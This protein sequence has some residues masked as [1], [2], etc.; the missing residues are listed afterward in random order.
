MVKLKSQKSKLKLL[1][2]ITL[3]IGLGFSVYY[4]VFTRGAW[5]G[6][7][8]FTL[9][10]VKNG[11]QVA[12]FDPQTGDGVKISFPRNWMIDG[13]DGKGEWLAEKAGRADLVAENLG[14]LY[15]AEAMKMSWGDRLL[16]WGWGR[17]VKWREV[18]GQL[19]MRKEQ[20]VDG[21][22]VWKLDERW[23]TA[24]GEMM[25]SVA[26]QKERLEVTVVNT[27]STPGLAAM[28]A[29]MLESSGLRVVATQTSEIEIKGCQVR[30]SKQSKS[31][32]GVR[33][34][35]RSLGCSWKAV[36]LGE[37]EA[38]LFFGQR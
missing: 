8:R 22:E 24:A 25:T 21:V 27:T 1:I 37:N 13:S 9:I 30:S 3:I 6:K 10:S 35:I 20:T 7:S 32:I 11:M 15:T 18:D 14:I 19:W 5:D 12:S 2:L 26:V 28:I 4:L 16:W 31:K 23:D 29:K 38:E 33:L 36:D 17:K 34:M